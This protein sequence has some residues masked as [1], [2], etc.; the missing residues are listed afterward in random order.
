VDSRVAMDYM[1]SRPGEV[2]EIFSIYLILPAALNPGVYSKINEHHKQK[3]NVS[4]E[5]SA[6]G[7]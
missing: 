1:G 4:E 6:A 3:N 7:A 2:N 5:S